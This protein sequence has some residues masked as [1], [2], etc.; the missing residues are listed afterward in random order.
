[1][2]KNQHNKLV[3]AVDVGIKTMAVCVAALHSNSIVVRHWQVYDML[4]P[5][6]LVCAASLKSGKLCGKA[7]KTLEGF[8]GVHG[9]G[10]QVRCKPNVAKMS[11]QELATLVASFFERVLDPKAELLALLR[12]ADKLVVETQPSKNVRMKMVSHW[13][14]LL[15]FQ[16]MTKDH[17]AANFVPSGSKK[18][19]LV[20]HNR[21][22][23]VE[24]KDPYRRRKAAAVRFVEH[25]LSN[26]IFVKSSRTIVD[27]KMWQEQ[28]E[29]HTKRDDL[30]DAFIMA[31]NTL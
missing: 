1:M 23:A 9:K 27:C 16:V 24:I 21:A 2:I 15:L 31:L 30:S 8:C 13:A 3:V 20:E 17:K 14:Y 12:D 7:S 4:E 22:L 19:L 5:S 6:K 10:L 26:Q 28:F 18:K 25:A 11:F 29:K